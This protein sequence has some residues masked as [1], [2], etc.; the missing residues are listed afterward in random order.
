MLVAEK[1]VK[2]CFI[3]FLCVT[4]FCVTLQPICQGLLSLALKAMN[5]YEN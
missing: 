3:F 1:C 5:E 2:I 4:H